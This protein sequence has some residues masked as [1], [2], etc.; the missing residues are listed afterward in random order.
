MSPHCVWIITVGGGVG[1]TKTPVKF[2]NIVKLTEL[3]KYVFFTELS[4][5]KCTWC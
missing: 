1:D 3:G 4:V 2:P 5:Y